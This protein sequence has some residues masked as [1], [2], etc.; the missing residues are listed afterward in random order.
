MYNAFTDVIE[1]NLSIRGAA[2]KYS[3]PESTLRNRVNGT[4]P[5]DTTKSG[6]SPLF[7]VEEEARLVD[8]LNIMGRAG[9]GYSRSEVVNIASDY[10]VSLGLR[11][12][13][14]PLTLM[15]FHN[16]IGRWPELKVQ[17]PRS[18][19]LQRAKATSEACVT[20]YFKEYTTNL[21]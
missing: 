20:E 9:Y 19:S 11:D 16:F 6:Q 7:S 21:K 18:L 12:G 3:L 5:L 8:H 4:V 1:N 14:H 15:R 2:R 13:D 10:A 17:K